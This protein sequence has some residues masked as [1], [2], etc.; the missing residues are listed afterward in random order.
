[1]GPSQSGPMPNDLSNHRTHALA[2][3]FMTN[4]NLSN[5]K[6]CTQLTKMTFHDFF[7][8]SRYHDYNELQNV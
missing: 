7:G 6:T 8:I 4:Q 2:W 5:I 1:M 3:H